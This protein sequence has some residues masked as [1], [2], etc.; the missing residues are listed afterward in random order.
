M[1]LLDKISNLSLQR[2]KTNSERSPYVSG[3]TSPIGASFRDAGAPSFHFG[4][5]PFTTPNEVDTML[6]R[7]LEEVYTSRIHPG[8]PP[9]GGQNSVGNN[10][11]NAF[12]QVGP[13][14]LDNGISGLN[15]NNP[16]LGQRGG[17]YN[18]DGPH[19][20]AETA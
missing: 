4:E 9:T 2:G 5:E 17:Q 13:A 19:R 20:N 15:S 14:G 18:S 11:G 10:L 3:D 8:L 6:E 16:A 1:A 7:S 12:P